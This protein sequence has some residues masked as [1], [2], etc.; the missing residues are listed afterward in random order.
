M[1]WLVAGIAVSLLLSWCAFCSFR[2]VPS[3]SHSPITSADLEGIWLADYAAYDSG[4]LSLTRAPTQGVEMLV[5]SADGTFE[6]SFNDVRIASGTWHLVCNEGEYILHLRGGTTLLFGIQFAHEYAQGKA[7]F[8]ALDW[9]GKL[10]ELDGEII[11]RAYRSWYPQAGEIRLQH[12]PAGDPDAPVI[13]EFQRGA[14]L[15]SSQ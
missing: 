12:I 5:L 7:R 8:H 10:I 14:S 3:S 11:L 2:S 6:Q 4:S 1:C 13:V 9:H 15:E